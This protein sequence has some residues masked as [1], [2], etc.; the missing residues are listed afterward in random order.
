MG[1]TGDTASNINGIYLPTGTPYNGHPLYKKQGRGSWLL[2]WPKEISSQKLSHWRVTDTSSKDKNDGKGWAYCLEENL[3]DPTQAKRW[4]EGTERGAMVVTR[5]MSRVRE[6][7]PPPFRS[8]AR[9]RSLSL[10]H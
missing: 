9:A 1:A 6:P 4:V 5:D 10:S 3:D 7:L 2:F 8:R